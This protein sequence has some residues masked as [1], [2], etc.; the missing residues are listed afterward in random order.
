MAENKTQ[1]T[2]E[3]VHAFLDGVEHATRREDAKALLALMKRV[4]G[5]TPR[6]WGPAMVGF[7][8]Y[9]YRYETGR[10]GEMLR[11]GFSPRKGNLALYF[12]AKPGNYDDLLARLGKYKTGS[13]CLYLNRLADADLGVL[14]QMVAKSWDASLEKYPPGADSK[15]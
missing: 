10:E 5:V 11:V 4:T 6:M 13:S 9:H 15:P 2:R 12:T 3:S 1:E 7:G 14:E 8:K